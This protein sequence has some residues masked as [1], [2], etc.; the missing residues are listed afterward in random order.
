LIWLYDIHLLAQSL[1]AAEKS[2]FIALCRGKDI[3][4]HCLPV[5][6]TAREYFPSPALAGFISELGGVEARFITG[7]RSSRLKL[8]AEDL[9]AL[10]DWSARVHLLKEHA[11]PDADYM[12][13]RFGVRS[14]YLLPYYY[15]KRIL[16]GAGSWLRRL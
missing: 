11:I 10:P 16:S 12:Q 6:L 3:V 1:N 7:V 9:R 14:H 2:R 15:V 8:L 4:R 5:L 13:K